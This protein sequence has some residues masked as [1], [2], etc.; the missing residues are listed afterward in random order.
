M[1]AL[2]HKVT[3]QLVEIEA[4]CEAWFFSQVA[5]PDQWVA[6]ES[7]DDASVSEGT[8]A[9]DVTVP[10]ADVLPT[11]TTVVADVPVDVPAAPAADTVEANGVDNA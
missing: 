1:I 2:N 11:D 8:P 5:D 3:E 9:T 7:I 4:G 6:P 10:V